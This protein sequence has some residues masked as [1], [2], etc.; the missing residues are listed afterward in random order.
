MGGRGSGFNGAT[1]QQGY[2][3]KRCREGWGD[4][5][6]SEGRDEVLCSSLNPSQVTQGR[7]EEAHR[8]AVAWGR[9]GVV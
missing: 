2:S 3:M 8:Q 6:E 1:A 4:K 9:R 5:E 7:S